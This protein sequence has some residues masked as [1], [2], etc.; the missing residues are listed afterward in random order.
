MICYMDKTW[1]DAQQGEKYPKC[2][3]ALPYAIKKQSKEVETI[4]EHI[5]YA[6]RDMSLVCPECE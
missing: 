4:E 5:P 2:K 6:I 3:K 1:C